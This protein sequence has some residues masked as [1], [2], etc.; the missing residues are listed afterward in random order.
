MRKALVV[1]LTLVASAAPTAT[2]FAQKPDPS[3]AGPKAP[4]ASQ[5]S[6]LLQE[7]LRTTAIFKHLDAFQSFALLPPGLRH[8]RQRQPQGAEADGPR[9]GGRS[10]PLR[11]QH[12]LA[13]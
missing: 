8:D 2:A 6:N 5:V 10:R 12:R 3:A 9:G 7:G 1:L 13:G 11:G 4:T